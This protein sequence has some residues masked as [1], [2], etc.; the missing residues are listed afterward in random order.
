VVSLIAKDLFSVEGKTVVLTGASGY[1]GRTI[2]LALLSNGARVVALGRSQR[3]RTLCQQWQSQF[4]PSS[5]S[6]Y[7]V[8]M[9][10]LKSLDRTLDDIVATEPAIDVVINNAHELGVATGFNTTAGRLEEATFDH[11][12]RN[13]VGGM[14]WPALTTQKFGAAMKAKRQGSI[15]NVSTMYA[16]VAPNPDLYQGTELSNPPGYSAAK[17]AMIAFTRYTASF[18]GV[19]GIRANAVLPGP[20]S[21]T[22]DISENSVR[23]DDPFLTKLKSKTCL[24]RIGKPGELV[25][26]IL[27]L[28]SDASSYITGHA[29]V[30]DGGWTAT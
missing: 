8:D 21:N 15:I 4:G 26:A 25:G 22:D 23:S 10:D 20:F 27:F 9:Y 2:A 13:F 5:V 30:V 24:G 1:L 28:S 19:Y 12:F 16:L 14:F 3:L 11:W 6:S 29:L 18:W 7:Q 17:S